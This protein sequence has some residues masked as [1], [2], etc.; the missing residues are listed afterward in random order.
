MKRARL[1]LACL[2]SPRVPFGLFS[3]IPPMARRPSMRVTV[4]PTLPPE[5]SA[6]RGFAIA[7][8]WKSLECTRG[9]QL[10]AIATSR[11]EAR[12]RGRRAEDR[13]CERTPEPSSQ[14]EPNMRESSNHRRPCKY[15]RALRPVAR[16]LQRKREREPQSRAVVRL[17]FGSCLLC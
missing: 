16:V 5:E 15:R 17:M 6:P 9:G 11:R 1:R 7:C 10:W 4:R 2:G 12:L 13:P 14:L 8:H 3:P